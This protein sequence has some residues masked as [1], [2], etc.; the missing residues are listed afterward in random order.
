MI[1]KK[2]NEDKDRIELVKAP[3]TLKEGETLPHYD[4][5]DYKYKP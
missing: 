1:K 4:K 3:R 5:K 2:K